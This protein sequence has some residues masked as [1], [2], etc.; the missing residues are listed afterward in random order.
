ML[1]VSL[2]KVNALVSLN[3]STKINDSTWNFRQYIKWKTYV[4]RRQD[5]N[6]VLSATTD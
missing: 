3:Y 2:E 4:E 6:W 1:K 5:L